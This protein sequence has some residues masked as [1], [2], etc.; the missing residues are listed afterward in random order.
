VIGIEGVDRL[1]LGR[2]KAKQQTEQKPWQ[3][4]KSKEGGI[5]T[6]LE[7]TGNYYTAIEG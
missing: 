1:E 4:R 7:G 6:Y 2:E 5:A 3:R